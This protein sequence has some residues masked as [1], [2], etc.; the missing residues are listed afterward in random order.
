MRTAAGLPN[1]RLRSVRIVAIG[2]GHESLVD[3]MLKGLR[4]LRPYIA[5]AAVTNVGLPFGEELPVGYGPMDRMARSTHNVC[6]RVVAAANVGSIQVFRMASKT[7]VENCIRR[8]FRE[9]D[10]RLLTAVRVDVSFPR[11]VTTFAAGILSRD[12]LGD[13]RFVV[14]IAEKLQGNIR[15]AG[16]ARHAADVSRIGGCLCRGLGEGGKAGADD[17]NQNQIFDPESTHKGF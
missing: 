5:M 4:K 9:R 10:N 11:P 14:G 13:I 3:P 8:Q 17:P 2:T 6:L 7:G 12:R 16:P 1:G 15:V